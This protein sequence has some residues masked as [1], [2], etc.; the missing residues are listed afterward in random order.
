MSRFSPLPTLR[1]I[2]KR[3]NEGRKKSERCTRERER[4]YWKER[5]KV[6][7]GGKEKK[8]KQVLYAENRRRGG[9]GGWKA[10]SKVAESKGS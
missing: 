1:V 3:R 10:S 6:G 2:G 9:G 4:E 8:K 5:Y 7:E